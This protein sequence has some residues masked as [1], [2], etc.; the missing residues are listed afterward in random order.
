MDNP[1]F[2]PPVPLVPEARIPSALEE[3][4]FDLNGFVI[5]RAALSA[6]EVKACNDAVDDI[7]RD[8]P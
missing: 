6:E 1:L 3:Y 2:H 4:L 5:I 7:P 8:L